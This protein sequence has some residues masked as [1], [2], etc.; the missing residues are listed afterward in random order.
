[1]TAFEQAALTN[2]YVLLDSEKL[3][4]WLLYRI[5]KAPCSFPGDNSNSSALALFIFP[6]Y[7]LNESK[8]KVIVSTFEVLRVVDK[9]ISPFLKS[10]RALS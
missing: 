9:R 1:M 7:H 4:C 8:R 6:K 3:F 5:K 10:F 2:S